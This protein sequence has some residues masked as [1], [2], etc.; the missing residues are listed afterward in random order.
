MKKRPATPEE[1]EAALLAHMHQFNTCNPGFEKPEN[2]WRT[3]L[4]TALT[5]GIKNEVCQ[6]GNVFLAFHHYTTCNRD[7]CPF[8]CGHTSIKQH[9]TRKNKPKPPTKPLPK[10]Q[11]KN[12]CDT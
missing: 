6:C 8:N 3:D 11:N 9:H 12:Q 1:T 10:L 7:G 5:E 2:K 4:A